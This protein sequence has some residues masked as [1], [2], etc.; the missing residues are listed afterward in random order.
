[1]PCSDYT[2]YSIEQMLASVSQ[3]DEASTPQ[4]EAWITIVAACDAMALRLQIALGQLM[5]RWIPHP[6]SAAQQFQIVVQGL[7]DSMR[8]DSADA[9]Q[10]K[11]VLT[12]IVNELAVAKSN[13]Q[14]IADQQNRYTA[15]EQARVTNLE[16]GA[17]GVS[18]L[19]QQPMPPDGWREDLHYQ[20]VVA[21]KTADA[22]IL[23]Y[24]RAMPSW[25]PAKRTKLDPSTPV[26]LGHD[27]A[28][29]MPPEGQIGSSRPAPFSDVPG[30]SQN[31]PF[32]PPPVLA[33]T[34][35]ANP[36]VASLPMDRHGEP[37]ASGH[38]ALD[39][40]QPVPTG[41]AT[42][43]LLPVN[44]VIGGSAEAPGQASKA[45][46]AQTASAGVDSGRQPGAPIMSPPMGGGRGSQSQERS[47]V[48]RG[49]RPA[50]WSSQ[51]RR[52]ASDP[53]D[54]WTV[55]SGVPSVIEAPEPPEHDPGPG[56]IGFH[57]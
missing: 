49:G 25:S 19:E 14:A 41:G 3:P 2:S 10:M 26:V 56:V 20:A 23:A 39:H 46:S 34:T 31:A 29:P 9:E 6:G 27:P 1:M 15:S 53:T 57:R 21:L 28:G 35:A 50:L 42:S 8:H 22:N 55:A 18:G 37:L 48:R 38:L 45:G 51:R 12:Q 44:G 47:S 16:N 4:L 52:K 7:I 43:G 17:V 33:G 24:G 32:L 54:E 40:L 36:I 13:L 30:G 5:E 11:P